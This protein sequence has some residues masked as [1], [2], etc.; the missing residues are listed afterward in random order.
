MHEFFWGWIYL[1]VK[2]FAFNLESCA[3]VL[4]VT[5]G[6]TRKATYKVCHIQ[7][8][9]VSLQTAVIELALH[10]FDAISI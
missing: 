4:S 7:R 3:A 9:E 5:R 10:Q 6:L 2:K 1:F 8:L